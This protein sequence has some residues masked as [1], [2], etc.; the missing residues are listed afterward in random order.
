MKGTRGGEV[1]VQQVAF[2]TLVIMIVLPV[3]IELTV[4]ENK[5]S[6]QGMNEVLRLKLCYYC[7]YFVLARMRHGN[8]SG[9]V[10]FVNINTL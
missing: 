6:G 10:H 5:N 2:I 1:D 3:R 8:P 7:V 9:W 4:P